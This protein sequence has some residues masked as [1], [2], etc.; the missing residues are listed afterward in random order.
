MER[1]EH[2]VEQQQTRSRIFAY[3]SLI[4]RPDFP[5]QE[6]TVGYIEGAARRFW[7]ASHDHRGTPQSPGRVATLTRLTGVCCWGVTYTLMPE[8]TEQVY[9]RLDVREKGGY[10]RRTVMFHP[11]EGTPYCVTVY[12]A[13][14]SNSLFVKDEPPEKTASVIAN[15][16]GPSGSN[17]EYLERLVM[18]LRKLGISDDYLEQ[19]YTLVASH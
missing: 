15:A 9:S 2:A 3:G 19:L 11:R 8:H 5:F 1:Q 14:A 7:Q 13:E 12:I 10:D 16:T 6:R 17:R 18:S 4:W